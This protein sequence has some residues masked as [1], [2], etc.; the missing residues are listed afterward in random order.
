M[1][2]A[3]HQFI[4]AVGAFVAL[5]G[6]VAILVPGLLLR[7]AHARHGVAGLALLAIGFA[8]LLWCVRDFY[9][10]GRGT[11]APWAP[12]ARLVV[13]GLYRHSRNPMY[14]AVLLMLVGW[15]VSYASTTLWLYASAV[16]LLFHWRVRRHEE[17]YL[18]RTHGD[19]W[20]AYASRVPRWLR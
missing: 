12:P 7:P 4:R 9:V 8:S 19:A 17:P 14:L 11:L 10:A 15:A 3:E 2:A 16:A 13:R 6:V 20:R 5:P 18:A 1:R